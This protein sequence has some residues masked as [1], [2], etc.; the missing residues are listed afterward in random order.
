MS[1]SDDDPITLVSGGGAESQRRWVAER[2]PSKTA[3]AKV[4]RQTCYHAC[5]DRLKPRGRVFDSG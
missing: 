2:R 5:S 4:H 3:A 1:R